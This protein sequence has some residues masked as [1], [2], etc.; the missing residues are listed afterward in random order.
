MRSPRPNGIQAVFVRDK[1]TGDCHLVSDWQL[2]A[3]GLAAVWAK[4][5]TRE[6]IFDALARKEVYGTTGTRLTVRIFAGWDFKPDEVQRPDFAA[7]G[8]ARGVPMGGDLK[9]APAGARRRA[10]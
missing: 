8:Y 9:S 1:K 2:G 10:S 3:S 5:N 4:E 7:Q 6:A